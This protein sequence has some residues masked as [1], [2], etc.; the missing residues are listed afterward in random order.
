MD[1]EPV[2]ALLHR[3]RWTVLRP[4]GRHLGGDERSLLRGPGLEFTE[5]REYQPGD[6]I[7]RIDWNA[8]ARTGGDPPYIR[9]AQV[10]RAID[11]WL[12]VDV[13]ASLDWGTARCLK[14]DL[15]VEF[16]AVAAELFGRRGNRVGALMF[17]G[18]PL[19]C[20]PPGS[21]RSHLVHLL[22]RLQQASGK[23]P[24]GGTD[25][26]AALNRL[27]SLMRRPSLVLVISDFLA[28]DGWQRIMQ[29]LALRHE[30]VAVVLRDPR[31]AD[32]PDVGL[33]TLEDPETGEQFIVNLSDNRLRERYTRAAAAQLERLRADLVRHGI[34]HLMLSTRDALLPALVRFL[35]LRQGRRSRER[36]L[37]AQ[38]PGA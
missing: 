17:A 4:L 9:E 1:R 22:T 24:R 29:R 28:S 8:T 36:R 34:E 16:A 19:Q 32:L 7:R 12:L 14:R 30:L 27:Q 13:S 3:L 6:D 31:E 10:E 15:A 33:V 37:Y 5:V 2:E 25:L 26:I 35:E 23:P 11:V 38:S 21:G 20:V 18:S